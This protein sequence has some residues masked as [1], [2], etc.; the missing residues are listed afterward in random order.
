MHF[1]IQSVRLRT[2]PKDLQHIQEKH[3]KISRR[4]YY[5]S[6]SKVTNERRRQKYAEMGGSLK[7]DRVKARKRFQFQEKKESRSI[8]SNFKKEI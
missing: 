4:I 5:Q 8:G 6:N 1:Q 7:Y 2:G 3:S